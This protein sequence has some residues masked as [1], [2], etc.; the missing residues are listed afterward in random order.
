MTPAADL[1]PLTVRIAGAGQLALAAGSLAIPRIL[2]WPED[3]ARL[4][5]LT[6]Q[7]FWVYA[8][9]IL[10]FHVAFGLLSA[11]AP[12]WL[13]DGSPLAGAVAGFIAVYWGAR[14]TLQFTVLDRRD[15]PAGRLIRAAEAALVSLFV[16]LTLTYAAVTWRTW[17][18]VGP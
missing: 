8:A 7:M 14:L 13:L 1:W 2:R 9:Y 12:H 4:R 3:T 5:P 10:S 15:A 11:L 18:G 16:G 6:R 17:A